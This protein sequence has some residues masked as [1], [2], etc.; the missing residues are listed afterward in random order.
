MGSVTKIAD[1]GDQESRAE[2]G[3]VV[4]AGK[5]SWRRQNLSALKSSWVLQR[6]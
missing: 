3:T 2:K 5:A 6:W 4:G 1:A